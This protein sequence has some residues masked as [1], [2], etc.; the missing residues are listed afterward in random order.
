HDWASD[1]SDN[2]QLSQS[3]F[4]TFAVQI[5]AQLKNAG[6]PMDQL[7]GK[8]H[9]LIALA[10]DLDAQ[11]GGGTAAAVDT[12]TG[13]LKGNIETL[14]NYGVS[15][16]AAKV[17]AKALELAHGDEAKAASDAI[18]QQATLAIIYEQTAD[19][20]GAAARESDSFAT[21]QQ[22]L[23][24]AVDNLLAAVGAPLLSGLSSIMGALTDIAP[25][26][27]PMAT[28]V[29]GLVGWVLHFPAPLLAAAVG[30][31]AWQVIGGL[32]GIT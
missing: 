28:A 27:T 11:F 25:L 19:A 24:G 9:D 23:G 15:I 22:K 1:T 21:Q 13:A 17:S 31:V 10:A 2:I 12:L 32:S 8:T 3:D 4:E 6:T 14:D 18:K 7:G 5:G 30:V 20:Q 26:I 29:A 16:S